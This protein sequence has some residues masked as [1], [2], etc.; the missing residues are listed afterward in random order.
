MVEEI[1]IDR[2]LPSIAKGTYIVRP[3]LVKPSRL[4]KRRP[5]ATG[6]D[7]SSGW[8][9]NYAVGCLHGCIFCYVDLIHKKFNPYKLNTEPRWGEYFYTPANL[10]QAIVETPWHR[11]SGEEV[12]MS[13]T[14]DPYL[15]QL[16][17]YTR[18]ILEKALRAGIR[19]RIQT[20]SMLVLRDL[21]FLERYKNR[22]ILQVS[23]AT[24][25]PRFARMIEPKVPSPERRVEILKKAKNHGLET[26]VIVA[27]IF[28][29]NRHRPSVEEDL[30]K[31]M[32]RLA[33]ANVDR[34]YGETLHVRGPNMGYIREALG[35]PVRVGREFDEWVEGLFYRLLDKYGL[36]GEYWPEK[37]AF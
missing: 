26:G 25:N 28:P 24:M 8:V 15:P 13:S 17:K 7:L 36:R 16:Y 9:I 33:E 23:I 5:D 37:Y 3:P 21:Q 34:V 14:H 32:S 1:T 20:R 19:V 27:P 18:A 11:W 31:I 2:T 4:T 35:G 22:V 10:W 6:K 29:P 30:D 12:L